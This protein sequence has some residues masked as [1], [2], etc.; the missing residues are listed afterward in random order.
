MVVEPA[1]VPVTLNVPL[2]PPP[3][4][5]TLVGLKLTFPVAAGSA[6]SATVRPAGGA[7]ALSVIVPERVRVSPIAVALLLS[8]TEMA[9]VETLTES[10]VG[11]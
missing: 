3:G 6:E 1:T 9:A 7:G 11:V 2:V 8:A 10:L 5:E 4:I